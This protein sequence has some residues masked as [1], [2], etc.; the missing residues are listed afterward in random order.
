[1]ASSSPPP[2]P[3]Q[4]SGG[5]QTAKPAERSS[6]TVVARRAR[7]Q[8]LRPLLLQRRRHQ[9]SQ[10]RRQQRSELR[11]AQRHGTARISTATITIRSS[12]GSLRR[13]ST[14]AHKYN[15]MSMYKFGVPTP[16]INWFT[17]PVP[18]G[19]KVLCRNKLCCLVDQ[20]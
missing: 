19:L 10:R 1:M 13:L 9:R 20:R 18:Y 4:Q 2:P 3:L 8:R 16:P 11:R 7:R 6:T 12:K 5:R 17:I 14:V 15:I